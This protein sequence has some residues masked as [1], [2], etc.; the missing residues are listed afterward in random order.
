MRS[1]KQGFRAAQGRP[2][3]R[4]LSAIAAV[5]KKDGLEESD[6][7]RG[8]PGRAGQ[9]L[10]M[11][12]HIRGMIGDCLSGFRAMKKRICLHS[13]LCVFRMEICKR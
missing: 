4:G 1:P 6:G 12:G 2:G 7:F 9:R 11:N 8:A 3:Q 13:S 10:K 5:A